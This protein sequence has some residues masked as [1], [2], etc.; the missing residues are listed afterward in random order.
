MSLL[1]PVPSYFLYVYLI[2]KILIVVYEFIFIIKSYNWKFKTKTRQTYVWYNVIVF[3]TFFCDTKQRIQNKEPE[4][5]QVYCS[6]RFGMH[7]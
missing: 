3:L 6:K 7:F 1:C 5:T 4:W 2:K